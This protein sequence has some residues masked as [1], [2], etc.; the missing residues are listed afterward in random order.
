M[1]MKRIHLQARKTTRRI[2]TPLDQDNSEGVEENSLNAAERDSAQEAETAERPT[3]FQLAQLAATLATRPDSEKIPP[4]EV[5]LEAL[6]LWDAA[7]KINTTEKQEREIWSALFEDTREE[8]EQRL[9]SYVGDKFNLYELLSQPRLQVESEVLPQLFPDTGENTASR[10]EKFADLVRYAQEN[11]FFAAA[12][13]AWH[14]EM[15]DVEQQEDARQ[16]QKTPDGG[17]L[18][19]RKLNALAVR[20][21]V[22]ARQE[23]ASD[24]TP[25]H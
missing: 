10:K 17:D 9:R 21:L 2:S 6:Q 8:W 16:L 22:E 5:V 12:P 14:P 3:T 15:Q 18:M 23:K 20:M 11:K 7:L 24:F 19:G 13:N 25:G 4:N 1:L